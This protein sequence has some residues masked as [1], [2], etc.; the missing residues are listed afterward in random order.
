MMMMIAHRRKPPIM[1]SGKA[2]V[3]GITQFHL[4]LTRLS[5][6]GMNHPAYTPSAFTR[7]RHPSG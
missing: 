2:R 7:W 5:T 4:P 6:S 3:R 1:R